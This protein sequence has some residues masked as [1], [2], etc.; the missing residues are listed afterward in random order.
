MLD[1]GLDDL[2][3]RVC[4]VRDRHQTASHVAPGARDGQ[5][6]PDLG[7][8]AS[9]PADPA[10][11]ARGAHRD[12]ARIDGE[13]AR[14]RHDANGL[15][16]AIEVRERL[17][18][19]LEDD[20]VDA[21]SRAEHVERT[22]RTCSTIS[23]T[24]RL[25]ERPRRP[26]AQKTQPSAQPTCDDT[27]ALNRP[28][29]SSGMR[30]VSNTAPSAEASD[31]F[32]K[33]SRRAPDLGPYLERGEPRGC[34]AASM[35]VRRTPCKTGEP[36][37]QSPRCTAETILR[38]SGKL[39]PEARARALPA[40]EPAGPA[41]PPVTTRRAKLQPCSASASASFSSS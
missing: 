33:G 26:V 27:H 7:Q 1:R 8:L 30:T 5:A 32:M 37:F 18:H 9:E 2:V 36:G 24:S 15:D 29:R 3:Q 19:P 12:G 4:L 21:L 39:G 14:L 38:A 10:R 22:T 28:A 41:C 13:S 23:Q 17:A 40:S 34:A 16:D 25:R 20:P 31:T 6:Q 35:T 11:H